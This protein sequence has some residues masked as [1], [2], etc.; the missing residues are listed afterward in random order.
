MSSL[1]ASQ[2]MPISRPVPEPARG[3]GMVSS[4]DKRSHVSQHLARADLVRLRVLPAGEQVHVRRF[5]HEYST[6]DTRLFDWRAEHDAR[7]RRN[8]CDVR[9]TECEMVH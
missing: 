5:V 9:R 2:P 7:A 8:P 1:T 6:H 4:V 3:P